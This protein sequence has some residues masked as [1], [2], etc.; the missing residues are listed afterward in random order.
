MIIKSMGRRK[1]TARNGQSVF[2]SLLNY[3]LKEKG[4][5]IDI[6]H[7]IP[8]HYYQSEIIDTFADNARYLHERKNGNLAYHEIISFP[9]TQH[10]RSKV[11]TALQNIGRTY[12]AERAPQNIAVGVIH[13]DKDHV[14][15]HLMLSS[16]KLYER[17]RVRLSREDFLA[18]QE[19]V[20]TK[21]QTLYPELGLENLYTPDKIR[22]NARESVRLT[23]GQQ[24][25]KIH[26]KTAPLSRK[27]Q[28]SELVHG[29]LDKHQDKTTLEAALEQ[30][31]F[32]LYQR[33]QTVGLVDQDGKKHRLS[34]LGIM[35]RYQEW[36]QKIQDRVSQK[37]TLQVK[38]SVV[39]R[40]LKA[41]AEQNIA[42]LTAEE[43]ARQHRE[44][45]DKVQA[46]SQRR[47]EE[48]QR[49]K[50]VQAAKERIEILKQTP[51][52]AEPKPVPIPPVKVDLQAQ[53][54]RR[55]AELQQAEKAR[56]LKEEAQKE[57]QEKRDAMRLK[58]EQNKQALELAEKSR[59]IQ[60][61]I[62]AMKQAQAE[63]ERREKAQAIQLQVEQDKKALERAEKSRKIKENIE[64]MRLKAEQDRA[65]LE[66]AKRISPAPQ[67][68]PQQKRD[69]AAEALEEINRLKQERYNEPST[70]QKAIEPQRATQPIKRDLKAEAEKRI[71]ELR[72]DFIAEQQAKSQ[73]KPIKTEQEHTR[74]PTT[75][76][77]TRQ[78]PSPQ[79]TPENPDFSPQVQNVLDSMR[80]KT[81]TIAQ[82]RSEKAKQQDV[83]RRVNELEQA[84]D[85]GR[86]HER[87]AER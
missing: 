73:P 66:Q 70:T 48:L 63:K 35:P 22:S 6:C 2:A 15:L 18:I 62:E 45:A 79:K 42:R 75:V 1:T 87:D 56:Q 29:L 61:N 64:A 9:V 32:V 81:E 25:Q 71:A 11:N 46:E 40:D 77:P 33:G 7:N 82:Q 43:R 26:R 83:S 4:S 68:V 21:A 24:Q 51:P 38:S 69:L 19:R 13:N 85:Q 80:Q 20:A 59:Q 16:N 44:I 55:V 12:L 34:T 57:Q 84:R 76:Q 10:D 37:E 28:L 50:A 49:A 30:H 39:K 52:I 86:D 58:A 5:K 27:E 36:Q 53:A 74:K 67:T 17:N 14:H 47:I 3:F 41:E 54:Q 23:Q 72:K 60:E 8:A 65:A 31:G 78:P